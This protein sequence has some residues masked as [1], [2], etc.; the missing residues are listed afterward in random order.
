MRGSGEE[1]VC[2]GDIEHKERKGVRVCMCVFVRRPRKAGRAGTWA[3][4]GSVSQQGCVVNINASA[5]CCA[6]ASAWCNMRVADL[7][8]RDR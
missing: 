7:V 4:G 1:R 8:P 3:A 6:A 5:S 2:V